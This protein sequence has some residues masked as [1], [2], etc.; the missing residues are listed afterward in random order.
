MP[1]SILIVDD[2]KIITDLTSMVL[3]SRGFSVHTVS[4]GR[5]ALKLA[6]TLRPAL[7]LLDYMMP[8]LDGMQVLRSLRT[9][10]PDIYVVMFTG[11]GSEELAVELMKA[12]AS[13]YIRKPFNNQDLVDRIENVLRIRRVEI[14]N[15]E[16][17]KEREQLLAEIAGWNLELERRVDE[18]SQELERA[19]AEVIQAEKLGA[20]G[21]L[22]AGLAHEIRNPL[23]SISLFSQV[24]R[25]V[26]PAE[27]E[28]TDYP[29]RIIAEVRRIDD[30]LVRLLS[31]SV[32]PQGERIPV[33]LPR[34]AQG[35]LDEFSEQIKQQNVEVRA[36][37]D[38]SVPEIVADPVELKQI[39][40]NLIANSLQEME[41]GGTLTVTMS[42][43]NGMV[44]TQ[45]ADSGP[46]IP[47]E[48]LYRVFDPFFTT[49][50]RGTGFGLP[51]VLRVVRSYNGRISAGN[52]PA[53]GA[54]FDIQLP[55]I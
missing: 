23:N 2:E 24:L 29:D 1:E 33:C 49:K 30:L 21:Q 11:K 52:Q 8:E 27:S 4:S 37:I 50:V 45:V 22:T 26:L 55:H 10:F 46:G 14:H 53:G 51:T 47:R 5:E 35:V 19:Q 9:N 6:E 38:P 54:C 43:E 18:K 40:S 17:L 31:V 41:A 7:V 25:Q 39:F 12:G 44:L 28:L 16:L 34:V 48:N 20:L 15:R 42:A 13:D 3:A 36:S 32:R